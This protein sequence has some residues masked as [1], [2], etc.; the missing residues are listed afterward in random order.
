MQSAIVRVQ[1]HVTPEASFAF[2]I[3][4]T[5]GDGGGTIN[6]VRASGTETEVYEKTIRDMVGSITMGDNK[7]DF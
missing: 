1:E 2:L 5:S 3:N 6:S 4:D 7:F